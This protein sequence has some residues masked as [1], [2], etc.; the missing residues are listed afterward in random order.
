M[1]DNNTRL[2]DAGVRPLLIGLTGPIGCGKSNIGLVLGE[3]GG[4]VID[5]DVLAR[6]ATD[7]GAPTLAQVR[8]RFGDNVFDNDGTLDRG[9]LAAVVFGNDAALADLERIVHPAVRILLEAEL[10]TAARERVPFVVIEAIKL[11][12]GGLAERCDEVWLVECSGA[13][14]RARL[15]QRG[16]S[17][18][19]LDRRLAAQGADLAGRLAAQ[20]GDRRG[21]RHLSTEGTLDETRA[22]VEDA[23][24]DALERFLADD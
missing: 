17:Q 15:A 21:V 14:Q 5:A 20:L 22:T 2:H 7:K 13:T 24:A 3:V 6:R 16:T 12:E 9:A 19:D 1:I 10:Q 8:D 11:V 23:L 18:A 4:T